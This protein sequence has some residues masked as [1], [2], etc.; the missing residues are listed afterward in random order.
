MEFPLLKKYHD[1]P[2]L[3][4]N[5]RE[6]GN[7]TTDQVGQEG[8]GYSG[9]T[10]T[11]TKRKEQRKKEKAAVAKKKDKDSPDEVRFKAQKKSANRQIAASEAKNMIELLRLAQESNIYSG[12]ELRAKFQLAENLIFQHAVC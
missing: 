12:Q 6:R 7:E 11:L 4:V 9:I 5:Q 8:E 1:H 2:L 3:Q 10:S